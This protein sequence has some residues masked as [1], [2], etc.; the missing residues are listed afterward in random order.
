MVDLLE[1]FIVFV[2]LYGV[3]AKKK[4]KKNVSFVVYC[5]MVVLLQIQCCSAPFR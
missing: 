4:K 2:F 5:W 1:L 3:V